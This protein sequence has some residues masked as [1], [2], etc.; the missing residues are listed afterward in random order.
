[1]EIINERPKV[2]VGIIVVRDGKVLIGKRLGAHGEGTWSFPGGHLEFGE[3]WEDAVA[4]EAREETG[5][6]VADISFAAATN[7][8]MPLDRKHYITI[9]MLARHRA[10]EARVCEPDRCERW[11]WCDW[12]DLP[13]PLFIP[14]QNLL[15]SGYRPSLL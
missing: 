9:Y 5:L 7:D 2:G 3:T 1:M 12:D 13:Q 10:G 15:R 4:R 14:L 6:E 8:I 11:E